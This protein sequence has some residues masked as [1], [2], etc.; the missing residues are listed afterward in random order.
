MF[1]S[2]ESEANRSVSSPFGQNFLYPAAGGSEE[3]VVQVPTTS[4]SN[5]DHHT[6]AAVPLSMPTVSHANPHTQQPHQQPHHSTHSQ[7]SQ[8]QS[9][10]VEMSHSS[11]YTNVTTTTT[12]AAQHN[13]HSAGLEASSNGASQPISS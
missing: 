5:A 10:Q 2:N 8:Q 7:Q 4:V 6:T 11:D 1:R 13:L 3:G 9:H 12:A